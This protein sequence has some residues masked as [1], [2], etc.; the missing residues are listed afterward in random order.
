L[1]I[2]LL[3]AGGLA[4]TSCSHGKHADYLNWLT[5]D[6]AAEDEIAFDKICRGWVWGTKDFK[7]ALIAEATDTMEEEDEDEPS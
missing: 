1:S 2:A 6:R 7:K 4:D 3:A 5:S